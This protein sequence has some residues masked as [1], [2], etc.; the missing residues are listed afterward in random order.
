MSDFQD[1]RV[2]VTGGAGFIGSHTVDQ[3]MNEG[4][5]VRVLDDFSDSDDSNIE[6]WKGENRFELVVGDIRNPD[7]V[8][9][10][11]EDITYVFHMAAKV[12]IPLSVE[13]PHYVFD[14]NVMG[15]SNLLDQCRKRDIEKVVFPSSASVYG[16]VASLPIVE[17]ASTNPISPYGVSKLMSEQ[18]VLTYYHTYGL[19]TTILRYF[20]VY[21]PRQTGG[22]YS[23]VISIFLK[24]AMENAPLTVDGDGQQTRDFVFVDDVVSSN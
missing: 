9:N 5:H 3:L 11:L 19:Q 6:Y 13:R 17:S 15:T 16:D 12:S 20:N 21:G 10:A 18:V 24:Q 2:L 7:V 8:S 1:T 22:A 23:G 14:V 4:A